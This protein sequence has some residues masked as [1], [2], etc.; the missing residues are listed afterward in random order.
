MAPLESFAETFACEWS[1]EHPE[2]AV[3][4]VGAETAAR[5]RATGV[6]ILTTAAVDDDPSNCGNA[7][8]W[9]MDTPE[10]VDVAPAAAVARNNLNASQTTTMLAVHR[11][12]ILSATT[13]LRM[14]VSLET[15]SH[16]PA[17]A[18]VSRR[19]DNALQEN[20]KNVRHYGIAVKDRLSVD[21]KERAVKVDFA[22]ALKMDKAMLQFGTKNTALEMPFSATLDVETRDGQLQELGVVF[23]ASVSM[24]T[25]VYATL[26]G[27]LTKESKYMPVAQRLLN[28]IN[29][30]LV[31]AGVVGLL[32]QPELALYLKTFAHAET[33]LHMEKTLQAGC[34][35]T[36]ELRWSRANGGLQR[37]KFLW[38]RLPN[39]PSQPVKAH[40]TGAAQFQL[41]LLPEL[42]FK[43]FGG[44][45]K[46]VL[47][48]EGIIGLDLSLD[49][50]KPCFLQ[51]NIFSAFNFQVGF[52]SSFLLGNKGYFYPNT[53]GKFFSVA[54]KDQ[55]QDPA[56][57]TSVAN[58]VLGQLHEG[59]KIPGTSG[60]LSS[61]PACLLP[62]RCVPVPPALC[63]AAGAVQRQPVRYG[64]YIAKPAPS[65]RGRRA[66]AQVHTD[67]PLGSVYSLVKTPADAK[68]ERYITAKEICTLCPRAADGTVEYRMAPCLLAG[69]SQARHDLGRAAHVVAGYRPAT[70]AVEQRDPTPHSSGLRIVF[71]FSAPH[72]ALE[73]K[74]AMDREL[75]ALMVDLPPLK[76]KCTWPVAIEL[77]MGTTLEALD[78][79]PVKWSVT[80]LQNNKPLT[81]CGVDGIHFERLFTELAVGRGRE[82]VLMAGQGAAARL[83]FG[84]VR[85]DT[86]SKT[87]LDNWVTPQDAG[88]QA[89]SRLVAKL[90]PF[91]GLTG[92]Q[93]LDRRAQA[94]RTLTLA[95]AQLLGRRYL[96]R[97]RAQLAD[98]LDDKELDFAGFSCERKTALL[99]LAAG[100]GGEVAEL[101]ARLAPLLLDSN[102]EQVRAMVPGLLDG[103]DFDTV[104]KRVQGL[105]FFAERRDNMASATPLLYG[106]LQC[107]KGQRGLQRQLGTSRWM[108]APPAHYTFESTVSKNVVLADP[109][110]Y[111]ARYSSGC[112]PEAD[113]AEVDFGSDGQ[114][115][116][117][118]V[119]KYAAVAFQWLRNVL[120]KHNYKVKVAYG[121]CC[122]C[123]WENAKTL[124]CKTRNGK[125]IL[126]EHAFGLAVDI[127]P[128]QNPLGS[129]L[130]TDMPSAMTD[131]ILGLKFNNEPVFTW[132]GA[133]TSTKVYTNR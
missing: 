52:L 119:H 31:R 54:A 30:V 35:V 49:S 80:L 85:L 81:Q 29:G 72:T 132:G 110:S 127:N 2:L 124:T 101:V 63:L 10:A 73:R 65:P 111:C 7:A 32:I 115:Q 23:E 41:R 15:K 84:L 3:I 42:S 122:R 36:L 108:H 33:Q 126:S 24:E 60:K 113:L 129:K 22:K 37:P 76:G 48:A 105:L 112:L 125:D 16:V 11:K 67:D 5:L 39:I 100:R 77:G 88:Y 51:G 9:L 121:Y 14:R 107:S 53:D 104:R 114:A 94:S 75:A 62:L 27:A 6:Q 102:W 57:Q 90:D 106:Y 131:E 74:Q 64:R 91:L 8:Y 28:K 128:E 83:W 61:A 20:E 87:E 82:V 40:A 71:Y 18:S 58:S 21:F 34:N 56:V 13:Y 120:C 70:S 43:I 93:A 96:A 38:R 118:R 46:P 68:L 116:V 97:L 17:H 98:A 86:L 66:E 123:I 25:T 133:W 103:P 47:S 95:D 78:S 59:A 92:Q 4:L 1:P 12:D 50:T 99:A 19:A 130:V 45:L 79:A 69:V 109:K 117:V 55:Q 44:I 89:W 26:D